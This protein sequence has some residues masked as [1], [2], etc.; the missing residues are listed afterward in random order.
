MTFT[1]AKARCWKSWGIDMESQWGREPILVQQ[2][3]DESIQ[4]FSICLLQ[5]CAQLLSCSLLSSVSQPLSLAC[6][7]T[8]QTWMPHF[9]F[10][11]LLQSPVLRLS[12][13]WHLSLSIFDWWCCSLWIISLTLRMQLYCVTTNKA[14]LRLMEMSLD[15]QIFCHNWN[16]HVEFHETM[17]G[18]QCLIELLSKWCCSNSLELYVFL[19]RFI[20]TNSWLLHIHQHFCLC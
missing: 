4:T 13:L 15:V 18:K 8:S 19:F 14:E 9:L 20:C 12:F 11:F 2:I 1:K 16:R 10:L 17:N 7:T 5:G 6:H 3:C